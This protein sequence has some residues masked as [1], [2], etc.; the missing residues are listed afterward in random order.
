LSEPAVCNRVGQRPGP[1]ASK[2]PDLRRNFILL[3]LDGIFFAVG[4]AFYDSSTV[5]PAFASTLTDSKFIIGLVGSARMFGWFLP[6]LFV[7]NLTE[8]L[9]RRKPL[10]VANSLLQRFELVLMAAITYYLAG[11][12]PRLALAL[13][14]PVFLLAALS[15]G[16]NG[17]P[18]TDVVAD[19]IPA[20][21]RGRL[22]GYQMVIGGV[23]AFLAGFLV[24]HILNTAPYPD[25]YAILFLCTAAGLLLSVLA[26]I[27]VREKPSPGPKRRQSVWSYF[28]SLPGVWRS[29]PDFVRLMKARFCMALIFLSQ[30]FFVLHA[31]QNLGVD[32][33][34]VGTYVS[35]HMVGL[36]VG[37]GLAGRLSDRVGNRVVVLMALLTAFLAPATALGLTALH[38]VGGGVGAAAVAFYPV[39]YAFLGWTYGASWIGFTNFVIDMAPPAER[40]TFIGLLNTLVAPFAF[41]GAV[42]GAVASVLGYPAV[43][44][45]SAAFALVGILVAGRLPEPR[46]QERW[47]AAPKFRQGPALRTAGPEATENRQYGAG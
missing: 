19:A 41:L 9:R 22:F 40:P 35:A 39:V 44:A 23:L 16:V 46:R 37:S 1:S 34:A 32:V 30:P 31:R 24:R 18:W 13:F 14:L 42:G 26:F 7:A 3:V 27:G 6:Q 11:T 12:N 38:L 33:G 47:P 21:L 28:R 25:R 43:F 8:S 20:E 4:S 45:V 36:L 5:L 29:S 17:V 10:V 2:D 15:E